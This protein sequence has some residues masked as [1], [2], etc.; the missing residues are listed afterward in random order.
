MANFDIAFQ[1]TIFHEGGYVNDLND[2]GGET[3]M[4][5]SRRAHPKSIIWK[6]IDED[7][8]TNGLIGINKRLKANNWLT[9]CIK[10]IYKKEYWDRFELDSVRVQKIANEIFD[11]CV[12]RGCSAAVIAISASLGMTPTNKITE[13][14][15]YNLK[16]L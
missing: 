3:Y 1:R 16:H 9:S 7:K 8:R 11:D 6:I 4:G 12:N 13:A 5:I 2:A 10:D 15:L 14:L